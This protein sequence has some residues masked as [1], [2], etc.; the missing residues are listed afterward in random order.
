MKRLLQFGIAILALLIASCATPWD[1]I[2]PDEPADSSQTPQVYVTAPTLKTLAEAQ[3]LYFGVAVD[4]NRL[5][6]RYYAEMTA[7]HF[8]YLTPENHMKWN[9]LQPRR[10]EFNFNSADRI[11]AFAKEHGM[12]VRGHALV[13]HNQNPTW[14]STLGESDASREE[15][16]EVM[17]AH[18]FEV[19]GH[20][21]DDVFAWDVVNEAL[22]GGNY[23]DSFWYKKVGPDY[24][25]LAFQFAHEAAPNARLYYN[26]YGVETIGPKSNKMY[27][28]ATELLEQGIPIHGVGLQTHLILTQGFN[29]DSFQQNIQRFL[30]LGLLVDVTEA[31]IR[32]RETVSAADFEE[33]ARQYKKLLE[34]YL[35]FDQTDTFVV[36]GLHDGVSWIPG[37]F[38][39]YNLPL[40]FDRDYQPK[41]A[42]F[43]TQDALRAGRGALQLGA[44]VAAEERF[45]IPS[46]IA[47]HSVSPPN[48]DGQIGPGEWDQAVHYPLA[49]NQLNS[50][51]QR[52]PARENNSGSW[53]VLYNGGT[54][55]GL[56]QREDDITNTSAAND[57][58]NDNF[59][60]FFELND[61][62]VQL[63]T[64]V[65]R[66]FQDHAYSGAR[67]AVW[68]GDGKILEFQID[69]PDRDLAGLLAGW[70]VAL[71]DNDG[72]GRASQIYP[73]P[74][75]NEGYLGNHLASITFVGNSARMPEDPRL[76]H[77]FM[78]N[79][80][81]ATVDGNIDELEWSTAVRYPMPYNQLNQDRMLVNE[82]SIQAEFALGHQG[83]TIKGFVLRSDNQDQVLG[84]DPLAKDGILIWLNLGQELHRFH[85]VLNQDFST[86]SGLQ[87]KAVWANGSL[88]FEIQLPRPATNYPLIGFNLAL[89]DSDREGELSAAIY[90]I[91][92]N[93]ALDP[94]TQLAELSLSR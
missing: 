1:G 6:N 85:A 90:P 80:V 38:P 75:I 36:W 77:P 83:N 61:E 81:D 51:D 60:V 3:D 65:G 73:V 13:W 26:D 54:I 37:A 32:I 84:S 62:F 29:F 66:D 11:V 35:S 59:E 57:Y 4:A 5:S 76:A 39:G 16:I 7:A 64:L 18:I 19:A 49:Y 55:Y 94:R 28:M 17:R 87:S 22:D 21:K 20:Y 70:N 67:K 41:P 88:E 45:P 40:L 92:G 53:A 74:G 47:R 9:T 93:P 71:S 86:E 58:E 72:S 44:A 8:N 23:R 89:L 82:A 78:V 56:L 25:A 12:K 2:A 68:S 10:G 79:A 69:L 52:P 24:I 15:M 43:A 34:V 48:I 63:R 46:F 42:Y 31:D 91:P 33:Q 14:L 30:D 27:E 50:L